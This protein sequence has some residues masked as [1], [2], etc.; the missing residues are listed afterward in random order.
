MKSRLQINQNTSKLLMTMKNGLILRLML[1]ARLFLS[2]LSRDLLKTPNM[3]KRRKWEALRL[4]LYLA[5]SSLPLPL[6]IPSLLLLIITV[7]HPA[8]IVSAAVKPCELFKTNS[9]ERQSEL[10]SPLRIAL[11]PLTTMKA[12][13][14]GSDPKVRGRHLSKTAKKRRMSAEAAL[15]F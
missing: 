10:T 14:S 12:W 15:A 7:I 9:L 11:T 13:L 5:K 4:H 3:T 6:S 2:A 8:L 1:K